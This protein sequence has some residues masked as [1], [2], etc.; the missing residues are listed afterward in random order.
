MVLCPSGKAL[1]SM[2]DFD[3]TSDLIYLAQASLAGYRT[4][5]PVPFGVSMVLL[6]TLGVCRIEGI[7]NLDLCNGRSRGRGSGFE[8][9]RTC[10]ERSCKTSIARHR[11]DTEFLR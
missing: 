2:P 10:P 7:L 8:P 4:T 5:F 11:F 3:V 1:E 9:V 6:D